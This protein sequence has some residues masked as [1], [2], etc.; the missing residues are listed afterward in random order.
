MIC[1]EFYDG[2]GLGNQLWLYAVTR[3]K[4]ADLG[5]E[6]GIISPEKF[7]GCGFLKLNFGRGVYGGEGPEGGPPSKLPEGIENYYREP[8]SY[9][10]TTQQV[11]TDVDP[12]YFDITLNTKIDGNFQNEMYI[13]HK[14]DEIRD[15]LKF[16]ESKVRPD[17]KALITD[18][19]CVINFR[20]GEYRHMKEVILPR[21]YW[22]C[23]MEKMRQIRKE[24]KFVVVTDD[25]KL[26]RIYFGDA[27]VIDCSMHEDYFLIQNAPFLILSNSSFAWFPAWL[28]LKVK[29]CIAPKYWWGFNKNQFWS[30]AYSLTHDWL[31]LDK[32]GNFTNYSQM[33][34]NTKLS[35][36][37]NSRSFTGKLT[38][39]WRKTIA[40]PTNYYPV[41][42][43][44]FFLNRRRRARSSVYLEI[45]IN[46]LFQLKIRNISDTFIRKITRGT[47]TSMEFPLF[48]LVKGSSWIIKERQRRLVVDA[49]YFLNELEL[50]QARFDFLGEYVDY[51]VVCE[52]R[53]TFTG[54]VKSLV[55]WDN[56]NLFSKYEKKIIYFE[57]PAAPLRK[58]EVVSLLYDANLDSNMRMIA[59]RALTDSN[60]PRGDSPWLTEF[61]Q[62]ESLIIP[63]SKLP[64]E[65]LVFISDLDEFWNPN[66]RFKLTSSNILIFKQIPYIYFM[67]CQSDESWRNWTG[68]TLADIDTILET[69]VNAAR[70]H[71]RI[72][73]RVVRNGGWHFS[74][75][76]GRLRLL[77]KLEANSHQEFNNNE[78]K[79]DLEMYLKNLKDLRNTGAKLEKNETQLPSF[80]SQFRVTHPDWFLD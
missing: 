22:K 51:F 69:G 60:V 14:K 3:V 80:A 34:Q 18:S 4:A 57:I 35:A 28:N 63:L 72:K 2:Q 44:K 17:V 33:S 32:S 39:F 62:K 8:Q 6:F 1:T 77:E 78:I 24:M 25:P 31:Y 54:G 10:L 45:I 65:S 23:A 52:S 47:Y 56:R 20:G 9:Y 38:N 13:L 7:K 64:L 50:L 30:P 53:Q 55:F 12:N 79:E 59:S 71:N 46:K 15:W 42:V 68:T 66:S 5:C 48:S 40:L 73:R 36:I 19:T 74:Y 37:S 27:E 11:S 16:D 76:G 41:Y 29:L 61:I 70:T 67:N 26:A 21:Y 75:Q 49:F 43:I 58:D